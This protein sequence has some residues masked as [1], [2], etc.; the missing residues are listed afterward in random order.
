MTP[1]LQGDAFV[2]DDYARLRPFAS[3]LPGIAGL[4]GVPLWAFYV[5]RGQAIAGFGVQD[6]DHPIMEFLPANKAYRTVS[7]HGFRTFLKIRDGRRT[8]CY[9]PFQSAAP[10]QAPSSSVPARRM[11]IRMHDL[12]LEEV[13]RALGLEIRV[14]YFTIPHEPFAGLARVVTIRNRMRRARRIELLDGLPIMI[15]YGMLDRFLKSMSRTIEA[16]THVENLER[17]APFLRLKVE[18]H[19]RP[20]VIP[21]HAGNFAVGCFQDGTRRRALEWVVDPAL[22]FGRQDDL[23]TPEGFFDAPAFRVPAHQHAFDKTPSAMSHANTVIAAGGEQTFYSLFGHADS[24]EQLNRL[25]PRLTDP[26]FFAEK[27]AANRTLIE[28]LTQPMATSSGQPLFDRYCR[29]TF[30]DNVLRGGTPVTLGGSAADRGRKIVYVY[31]RK[32]GDLERD[33]NFFVIPPTYFSQG[34][35]NYRDVNQNRRSNVW[36]HPEIGD[37]DVLTFFNLLQADGFNPLI[38]KGT[39]YLATSLEGMTPQLRELLVKPFTPGELLKQMEHKHLAPAQ[40]LDVFVHETM[41][42]ARE[43]EDAEHGEGF[44]TDHWTY[45]LDLLESYLALYPDRLK[46]LLVEKRV[47]TFYDN[48]YVV[49]PRAR[50]YRLVHHALRQFH[51]VVKDPEKAALIQSRTEEPHKVRTDHGRGSIYTTSLLAK[52]VCVIVNKAA[53]L[54]PEGVGI[55]MEAEKPNWYDALNG[56][57]GLVGSSLCETF[58]LKRW[59]LFVQRALEPLQT[60]GYSNVALPEEVV[61]LLRRVDALVARP[62]F[63]YWDQ[64]AE[65]KE[66]YRER[67]RLGFSGKEESLGVKELGGFLTRVLAKVDQGLARAYDAKRGLYPSYFS[68]EALEHR[69]EHG[70]S[71]AIHPLRWAQ[72]I[73]PIFLEG[74]VHALRLETDPTRAR[75]LYRAVRRSDLFDR[76]LRMYRVCAS[77]D[78]ESEE[79]GR[80]RVFNPGWLEHQS[81]WLHMEYKY[82]LELLRSGL[83]DEFYQDLPSTLIPF[84]PPRRYGRS[85]LENSSFLVSSAY[86]D[87][88]LHGAGFVARLSGATAEFLQMWVWMTVGKQPF[89]LNERGELELHLEPIL[90]QEFFTKQGRFAFTF[91]GGIDVTYMNPS[92]V[93][94]FGRPRASIRSIRLTPR[95]DAPI[96]IAGAVIPHPHATKVR[97][98][99]IARIDV[100]FA[101]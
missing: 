62:A 97:S 44:W 24:V 28:E 47:F 95:A 42:T 80:G 5:N 73:L 88:T 59:A 13:N 67:T 65:A 78:G 61:E 83:Y 17:Q 100:E 99:E 25:L 91:L 86:A 51:A 7:L 6:K 69:T 72:R 23:V 68:Y 30:L 54:D 93:K 81:I 45:T 22:I 63:E 84:Q 29:Q 53:S 56:L 15:P 101:K 9:E 20:E 66:R 32:H 11:H 31:S 33:Y 77:L 4:W 96:Q 74:A 70:D 58:E 90:S 14:H 98:G 27:D 12:V 89:R 8:I 26:A 48:P 19:D 35:A 64:S 60:D 18:P 94:T 37:Q 76:A 52:M 87:P 46:A 21:I 1:R 36:F 55:E 50:K 41:R 75:A 79:I 16:W 82:L 3:F 34:N 10:R 40:P 38:F 92:R 49:V 85:T 39:R 43:T 71:H 57:P 2:I